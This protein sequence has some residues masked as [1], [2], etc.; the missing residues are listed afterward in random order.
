MSIERELS[1]RSGSKCE[2]CSAVENLQVYQ[3]LPTKNGGI[4]ESIIRKNSSF[5]GHFYYQRANF[6]E[7]LDF[8]METVKE[9]YSLSYSLFHY[10]VFLKMKL[11]KTVFLIN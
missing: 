9:D 5:S 11:Q 4:D 2:L 10:L 3:V 6:R 7:K 8:E 1:S